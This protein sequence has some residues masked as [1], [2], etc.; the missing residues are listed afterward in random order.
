MKTNS[1]KYLLGSALFLL[2][3]F[4]V[5]IVL[6]FII[7]DLDKATYVTWMAFGSFIF[8]VFVSQGAVV[9]SSF[10]KHPSVYELNFLP[11]KFTTAYFFVSMIFN[12]VMM[13]VLEPGTAAKAIIIGVNMVLLIGY[14]ASFLMARSYGVRVEQQMDIVSGGIANK[15]F[16]SQKLNALLSITESKAVK[17]RLLKLKENVDYSNSSPSPAMNEAINTLAQRIDY[18]YQLVVQRQSEETILSYVDEATR[19]WNS[20]LR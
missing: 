1:N 6:F 13:L 8:S 15:A 9:V 11:L 16:L 14:M 10:L 18:I 3:L 20:R 4:L 19:V 17:A 2:A 7:L 5:W 12:T